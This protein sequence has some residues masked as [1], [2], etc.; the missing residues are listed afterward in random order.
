MFRRFDHQ[1]YSIPGGVWILGFGKISKSEGFG[2]PKRWVYFRFCYPAL[3]T[4][5]D[6]F[7]LTKKSN[8]NYII[9][10]HIQTQTCSWTSSLE[11]SN[12]WAS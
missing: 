7:L 8:D 6:H 11:I 10:K 5:H 9:N 4:C 12:I 3:E 1:S 2:G